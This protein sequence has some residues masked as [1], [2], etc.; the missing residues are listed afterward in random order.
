M[1]HSSIQARHPN[2]DVSSVQP[3]AALLGCSTLSTTQKHHGPRLW[4]L[5]SRAWTQPV[6]PATQGAR[7]TWLLFEHC[8][9]T[10]R[11]V[12]LS[13]AAVVGLHQLLQSIPLQAQLALPFSQHLL[14]G[15]K[16]PM[17]AVLGQQQAQGGKLQQHLRATFGRT[18]GDLQHTDKGISSCR[19]HLQPTTCLWA[20]QLRT[21]NET[22]DVREVMLGQDLLRGV[23]LCKQS[24]RSV[25]SAC[26]EDQQ[27]CGAWGRGV[28]QRETASRCLKRAGHRL[29]GWLHSADPTDCVMH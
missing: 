19:H 1:T 21:L 26:A 18:L 6:V 8:S 29:A 4:P 15:R 20:L 25:S 27:A 10:M 5:Q 11:V 16:L 22:K 3:G 17:V 28:G 7:P 12:Y 9:P 2:A 24:G 13:P 14:S 23:A